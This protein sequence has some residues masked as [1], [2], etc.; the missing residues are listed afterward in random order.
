MFSN[1]TGFRI[2]GGTFYNV[3]GDNV[4]HDRGD[5]GMAIL[6]RAA[7]LD[8]L[9][10]SA[11]SFPQPRCHPE[12]RTKILDNLYRWATGAF[13]NGSILWLYGPAGAGKSAIMQTLSRRLQDAGRLGGSFFFKRGHRTRGNAKVLFVTLAYQL[14]IHNRRLK[15][16]IS[17]TVEDDP[18]VVARHMDDQFFELIAR[19]CQSLNDDQ[20]HILLIDGLDEC[21]QQSAQRE[22]LRVV[23]KAARG[24]TLRL[25]ILIAS[26]PE[27]YIREAFHFLPRAV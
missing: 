20:P 17:K 6:H 8:A 11:E 9:Y 25:K 3:S 5:P 26:R 24:H 23:S 13:G 1:S 4:H 15:A 10:N 21:E 7:T 16:L 14:A 22:I 18:T 2:D 12:T 19:P 27:L